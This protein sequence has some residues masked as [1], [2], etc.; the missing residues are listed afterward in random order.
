MSDFHTVL[1][2]TGSESR[3]Q[4]TKKYLKRLGADE[5]PAPLFANGVAMPRNEAWLQ[6]MSQKID[7]DL[8]TIQ[9]Q[10]YEE[11]IP[12]DTWLAGQYLEKAITHRNALIIPEDENSIIVIDVAKLI[13]KHGETFQRLPRLLAR[14]DGHASEH[15]T[16]Q[17]LVVAD[18][19]SQKGSDL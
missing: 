10:L 2:A 16:V 3:V 14:I 18:L 1:D 19:D 12:E 11:V 8:R 4:S 15:E 13:N 17:L 9:R 5:I 6:T 7:T